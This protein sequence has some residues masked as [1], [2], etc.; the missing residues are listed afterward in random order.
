MGL[1]TTAWG[2]GVGERQGWSGSGSARP[3]SPPPQKQVG[4]SRKALARPV[5]DRDDIV[6]DSMPRHEGRRGDREVREHHQVD[7]AAH[8]RVDQCARADPQG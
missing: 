7:S 3:A 4:L 2:G 8:W 1:R 6:P 5:A